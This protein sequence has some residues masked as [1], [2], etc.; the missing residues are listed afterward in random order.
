MTSRIE[1]PD[2][3]ATRAH[4]A[5]WIEL[6]ALA[7]YPLA[8]RSGDYVSALTLADDYPDGVPN[9]DEE[10]DE[11]AEDQD[12]LDNE[13]DDLI[14]RA[15]DELLWRQETLGTLYPFQ[16][17]RG[18]RSWSLLYVRKGVA[19]VRAAR[20]LYVTCL[21]MSGARH[22]RLDGL[23]PD[24][25]AVKTVADAFQAAVF[26][27]APALLGGPSFWIAFPRPEKD[28]YAP[29]L[30]R[31][32]S[33]LGVGEVV[34]ARPPSQPAAKDGGVD[35]VTWRA[36]PDQRSNF[37]ISYGQVATG[38]GWRDKSVVTQLDSHFF[39]WFSMRPSKYWVPAMYIP[40]VMHEN[41]SPVAGFTFQELASDDAYALE[42]S[43]GIVVD[44]V[45]I[46]ALVVEALRIRH[47]GDALAVSHVRA[48]KEWH[49]TVLA[50]LRQ[51]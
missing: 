2:S 10:V 34:S 33:E 32:V 44:R 24:L 23:P 18:I 11:D 38:K 51:D 25:R 41:L 29:A 45:R 14:E 12:I 9:E 1:A 7:T 49:R 47:V 27:V 4:A 6:M 3:R 17:Q 15:T 5:D 19:S 46:T 20:D 39:R 43:L 28:D 8:Y 16:L 40:H 31:L 37:M 30:R 48:L 36:F 35:V 26:L 50:I 21:L 42:G 13:F 22:G